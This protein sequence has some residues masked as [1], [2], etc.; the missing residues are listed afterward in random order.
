MKKNNIHQYS[1]QK[2]SP[3]MINLNFWLK[4]Y[5]MFWVSSSF[6]NGCEL[7][8]LCYIYVICQSLLN[9]IELLSVIQKYSFRK[10]IV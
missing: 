1:F 5:D 7:V 10:K 2:S 9:E 3:N 4:L 6:S 8:L